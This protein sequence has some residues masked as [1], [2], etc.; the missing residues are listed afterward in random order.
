MAQATLPEFEN[1]ENNYGLSVRDDGK[2]VVSEEIVGE[3]AYAS[4]GYRTTN[5]DIAQIVRVSDS[6]RT[7]F[8]RLVT[9]TVENRH[10]D[11]QHVSPNRDDF[12]SEEFGIQVRKSSKEEPYF[13]GSYP[14]CDGG[15]RM[16]TFTLW[17]DRDTVYQSG[18]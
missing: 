15:E 18:R 7:V 9:K 16:G 14:F 2:P 3:F 4:Y 11:T 13:R 6:G 5:V 8:V 12:C 17:G 10:K 1:E